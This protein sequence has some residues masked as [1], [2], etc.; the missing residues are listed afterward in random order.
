MVVVEIMTLDIRCVD[1]LDLPHDI[2]VI[3]FSN[4]S[5]QSTSMKQFF[6]EG[7]MFL[8]CGSFD[9]LSSLFFFSQ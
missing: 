9:L 3:L 6:L 1:S 8:V 4:V 5:Y 2:K 7:I